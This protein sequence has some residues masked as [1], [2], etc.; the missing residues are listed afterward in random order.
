MRKPKLTMQQCQSLHRVLVCSLLLA[1]TPC[2]QREL[3]PLEAISAQVSRPQEPAHVSLIELSYDAPSNVVD[4][5]WRREY[6]GLLLAMFE[7]GL[8]E[9]PGIVPYVKGL[10][11]SPG[12]ASAQDRKPQFWTATITDTGDMGAFAVRFK[13]CRQDGACVNYYAR[14]LRNQPQT[15]TSQLLKAASSTLGRNPQ[16]DDSTDDPTYVQLWQK[17][18]SADSYALR[19]L[20][21]AAAAF[22]GLTPSIPAD[23]LGDH[24]LDPLVRVTFIDPNL[25]LGHWL[26]GRR[27][28]RSDNA[29]AAVAF[30]R[31]R[32]LN[33]DSVAL[34]ADEASVLFALGRNEEA[35]ELLA[36]VDKRSP[37]DARFALSRAQTAFARERFVEAEYTLTTLPAWAAQTADVLSMRVQIASAMGRQDVDELLARWQDVAKDAL[38]PVR[39]RIKQ[40]L[41][42]GDYLE[43]LQLSDELALRGSEN[44]ALHLRLS[45]TVGLHDYNEAVWVAQA[46]NEPALAQRL[47]VRGALESNSSDALQ[48]FALRDPTAMLLQAQVKF[49]EQHF[50]DALTLVAK[51]LETDAQWPEALAIKAQA[52]DAKGAATAAE[53]VWDQ[54]RFVD[55]V[56]CASLTRPVQSVDLRTSA[57]AVVPSTKHLQ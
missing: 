32:N 36:W 13:L 37:S 39:L 17:P 14:G 34:L 7:S 41:N 33:K 9:L 19:L 29:Q 5:P 20:G 43:A 12:L 21:R 49:Q 2:T 16:E 3:A 52:L 50:E 48:L 26:L 42:S 40:R 46:L 23:R 11:T 25:R 56:L 30:A 28:F 24:R 4:A 45:L 22:Y 31:A 54:L 55:P 57:A 38:E 1:L 15:V 35:S 44:E 53:R 18:L 51:V 10:Q 47:H 8:A 27:L 6:A